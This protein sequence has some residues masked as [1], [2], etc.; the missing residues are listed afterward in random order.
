MVVLF[1]TYMAVPKLLP[2]SSTQFYCESGHNDDREEAHEQNS[3]AGPD[4][5]WYME[6]P[7]GVSFGSILNRQ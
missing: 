2:R 1:Q 4:P 3:I 5:K 6:V 7:V